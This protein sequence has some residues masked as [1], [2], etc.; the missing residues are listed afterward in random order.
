MA[1]TQYRVFGRTNWMGVS[2]NA[3]LAF[4][5]T[6]G[7][8]KKIS[9]HS[10]E[11][12]NNTMFGY[13]NGAA[14]DTN[15]P[16]PTKFK[17]GRST[18]VNGGKTLTPYKMDSDATD[19]PSTIDVYAD[20]SVSKT[21]SQW[22]STTYTDGTVAI[23]DTTFTPGSAP[24]WLTNEHRDAARYLVVASGGN[25][26]TY[27]IV[28]NTTTALT[29]DPPFPAAVSTDGTVQEWDCITYHGVLKELSSATSMIPAAST[30]IINNRAYGA[31]TI[32]MAGTNS[33]QESIIIRAGEAIS[34]VSDQINANTP[35]QVEATLILEGSPNR[36]YTISYY[37]FLTSSES[38]IFAIDN[39]SGSGLVVRLVA[40]SVTE[41]GTQDTPYFQIVP[42]GGVDPNS[43]TDSIQQL[44]PVPT[45][46]AYGSLSTSIARIFA[47][48]PVLPYNVPTSYLAASS[49][50]SPIGF[51][52]LNTKD[53]IGPIFMTYFP[54]AAAY[55][56]PLTAFWTQS[57]PGTAGTQIGHSPSIIKGEFA[58]M[59]IRPGESFG[60]VSGAE[61]ATGTT[62]VAISG[63]GG[64][65]FGMTFTV[66]DARFPL[67]NLTGMA[68][69][70]NFLIETYPGL[71]NLYEGTADIT[72]EYSYEYTGDRPQDLRIR[73]RKSGSQPKYINWE[74]IV[75]AGADGENISV[76]VSQI[77]DNIAT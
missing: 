71:V 42:I 63:W 53:F 11:I 68:A 16:A 10:I 59:V 28:S 24:G 37:Q 55:K 4:T 77:P 46:S 38:A 36:T 43:S 3:L 67:I 39:N 48:A 52:Y 12:Y 30:G 74:V 27:K 1:R 34:V 9:V 76:Q 62:A 60:V 6:P 21:L 69:G 8:N 73:V 2:G 5:N 44:T 19:W 64:Y 7:S 31:G 15:A 51:N 25:A 56:P 58:P 23:G 66:E 50:G 32:F 26:G 54:E 33:N 18:T 29:I 49:A 40:L 35:V 57:V 70:S 22:G 17:I 72:G 14:T 41:V 47:N 20:C 13:Q 61:S 45:D 75:N 65:E